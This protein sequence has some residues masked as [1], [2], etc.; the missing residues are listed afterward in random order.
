MSHADAA[1]A[2]FSTFAAGDAP[3]P[4][5]ARVLLLNARDAGPE[6]LPGCAVRVQQS[7]RPWALPFIRQ[8]VDVTT[9]IPADGTY[10]AV[11]ALG[12]RQR[13]ESRALLAAG[14]LRLA[15]GGLFVAAA[16]NDAGGR[17]LGPDL[18]A[19]G[20]TAAESSKHHCRIVTARPDGF[21]RA[22]A[23]A[24]VDAA[25]PQQRDIDGTVFWTQPGLFGWDRR[26]AG[27]AL[28]L[29]SLTA[30]FAGPGADLGCGSG[31]LLRHVLQQNP[32]VTAG[33]GVD[34]DA[35]AVAMTARNVPDPRAQTAWRAVGAEDLPCRDLSW[36]VMNPPFHQGAKT[37]ADEGLLFISEAAKVL[38]PGGTLWLVA[39]AHLPYEARLSALFARHDLAVAAG[40]YKVYKA[41]K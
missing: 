28:L 4:A 23:Q 19:L 16:E 41:V 39:N 33:W 31:I 5:G 37:A 9:D 10:D 35:R 32:A 17:R 15:P 25:Q 40:G 3:L 21:D 11:L 7:L 29:Q 20:V 2:L 6:K 24:A 30:G 18:A 38:R 14:L 1:K 12:V 27:T 34:A 13:D 8:G 26:D 22:A 36:V